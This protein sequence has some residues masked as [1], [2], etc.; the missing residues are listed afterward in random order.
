MIPRNSRGILTVAAW[1]SSSRTTLAAAAMRTAKTTT[2]AITPPDD[3]SSVQTAN[4]QGTETASPNPKRTEN[5]NAH[6]RANRRALKIG[7]L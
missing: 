2:T 1:Y 7:H 4:S 3:A 5:G 6:F